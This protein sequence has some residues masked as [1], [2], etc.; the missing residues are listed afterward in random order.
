M[1]QIKINNFE[2]PLGLLL[3]LIERQ[4]M[5]ITQISLAKITDQY[6]DYIKSA[7]NIKPDEM[8][9]F[10]V[11]AAKLL[12]I[13]SKALLPYLYPEEKQE[14]EELEQQLK[15]YK[16]FLQAAKEIDN[17][18]RK[19]RFM[20]AKEFNRQFL[21][22]NLFKISTILNEEGENLAGEINL[23]RSNFF[24]PP[25]RLTANNLFTEFSNLLK[26]IKP[27]QQLEEKTLAY[28]I[29]IEDKILAIEKMLIE[30]IKFSFNKVLDDTT[31]KTEIIVS[32]L[33]MLELIKQRQIIVVQDD[34]FGEIE[35]NKI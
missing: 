3:Q 10:L 16:E 25:K 29:K 26:K 5:D 23:T 17:I 7:E 28:T 6:I 11:V 31:N 27:F 22:D 34:L 12:L 13:K 35:I 33:A 2:G 20:F 9:D 18:I 8:A 1:I 21:L 32:F 30:R 24:S 15:M 19:K 14:I 4:E